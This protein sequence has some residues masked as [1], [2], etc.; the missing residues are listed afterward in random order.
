MLESD[1]NTCGKVDVYTDESE[2]ILSL[3][4]EYKVKPLADHM[5]VYGTG[6]NIS[7][8]LFLKAGTSVYNSYGIS[9]YRELGLS[10]ILLAYMS[11]K[12]VLYDMGKMEPISNI[13]RELK[14]VHMSIDSNIL[15]KI[16]NN[17]TRIKVNYGDSIAST[18][19]NTEY[20]GKFGKT[21]II[22][23]YADGY[24]YGTLNL[25]LA[26][27]VIDQYKVNY[28]A[29]LLSTIDDIRSISDVSEIVKLEDLRNLDSKPV[30][31]DA[32]SSLLYVTYSYKR[33]E[34]IKAPDIDDPDLKYRS[35]L[36]YL[37]RSVED[38]RN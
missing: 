24:E 29:I 18:L 28:G 7:N 20:S 5:I 22:L 4:G 33:G 19:I 3:D 17:G 25:H 14:A 12:P 2:L 32:L 15:N 34:Y 11:N 31:I 35:D 38:V 16:T 27:K 36:K 6:E 26:N 10:N 9:V 37:N 8:Y 30:F 21:L 13:N 23:E 1:D